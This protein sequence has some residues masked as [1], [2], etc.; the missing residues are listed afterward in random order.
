M[1]E[2]TGNAVSFG[3]NK[4]AM[5]HILEEGQ[6][7]MNALFEYKSVIPNL[8]QVRGDSENKTDLYKQNLT[9]LDPQIQKMRSLEVLN[10]LIQETVSGFIGDMLQSETP[11]EEELTLL[12][13][14]LDVVLTL[15]YL[16]T[17]QAG[18]N[19][20]FSMY[21]RAIQHVKKDYNMAEDEAL[22]HFLINPNNI[23]KGL[24]QTLQKKCRGYERVMLCLA[25]QFADVFEANPEDHLQ[26]RVSVL[27]IFLIDHMLSNADTVVKARKIIKF[28]KMGK[29]FKNYP[30][31]SLY[32]QLPFN[33]ANYLKG[34]P[35]FSEI[36]DNDT[37]GGLCA[38]L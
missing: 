4:E 16:K 31:I 5:N 19:N 15:D 13:R 37:S 8:I 2:Q 12:G 1:T 35:N 28:G 34:C 29:L 38:I 14:V 30:R 23:I 36:A 17:W 27:S 3:S 9:V 21:R 20:D 10:D 18:L 26:L 32:K 7:H 11:T 25:K 33:V 6:V 24:K 22:R